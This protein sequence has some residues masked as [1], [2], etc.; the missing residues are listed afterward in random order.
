MK[1]NFNT[2]LVGVLSTITAMYVYDNYV[3]GNI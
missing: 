2:L 3:K 1:I